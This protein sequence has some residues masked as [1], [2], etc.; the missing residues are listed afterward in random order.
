ME[1][2]YFAIALLLKDGGGAVTGLLFDGT[3]VRLE[4]EVF[5]LLR[6]CRVLSRQRTGRGSSGSVEEVPK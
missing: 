4:A 3:V 1:E 6:I 5:L 2:V